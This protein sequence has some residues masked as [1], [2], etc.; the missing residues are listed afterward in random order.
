MGLR[1][2]TRH[3]LIVSA[4]ALF[5]GGVF[6]VAD[7][8][9]YVPQNYRWTAEDFPL[10]FRIAPEGAPGI[11]DGSD[12]EAIRNA[13]QTWET[14]GCSTATF[15]E[16]PWSEPA[17]VNRDT[18]NKV[19]WAKNQAD[20]N[21]VGGQ[22][23]T[24]ALTFV[25]YDTSDGRARDADIISN[26]VDWTWSTGGVGGTGRV[27]DVETVLL[28]E[29]GHFFGLGHTNDPNAVMFPQNNAASRR[30]VTMDDVNGICAL[31][32]GD[33][34]P[35]PVGAP[36]QA[37]TDC[38][39]SVC[40]VDGGNSYC[41]QQCSLEQTNNCPLD[42]PCQATAQG[43]FCLRP[44]QTDELCDQCQ[45]SQQCNTGLCLSVPG[46][47]NFRPFCTRACDPTPG[48]PGQCPQGYRCE[49]IASGNQTGGV[50][51]P[52]T[53]L[54]DPAGKGGHNEFCYADNSCKP[55]HTCV[56]YFAGA[57]PNYCYLTCTTEFAAANGSC[58]DQLPVQCQSIGQENVFGRMNVAVCLNIAKVGEPCVPEVCDQ[59]SVCAVDDSGDPE[60]ATC[61]QTCPTGNCPANSQC[62]SFPSLGP[63]C[64][65]NS[66]FLSLGNS[67]KSNE[68]CKSRKCRSYGD[69]NLCTQDCA[70]TD[71]NG[72]PAGLRCLAANNSTAGLCWPTNSVTP[73]TSLIGNDVANM[74]SDVCYCDITQQCDADCPCDP[75]CSSDSCGC[76]TAFQHDRGDLASVLLILVFVGLMR[77]RRRRVLR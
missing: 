54:C 33:G 21:A 40:V 76:T 63:V 26:G 52:N 38:A 19:F 17:T 11:N 24:L 8:Q 72:C 35:A 43:N 7:A 74:S 56:Q 51:A 48:A 75:E 2:S 41:S 9:A 66:G 4:L 13:F 16:D 20:W 18:R 5:I 60:T 61:Y 15:R 14:V 1:L 50:C 53:G 23:E 42:F 55:N 31:Y 58:S 30:Q 65:P 6:C 69:K 71:P 34:A 62:L 64:V 68:E 47:N 12:I 32:P 29:V 59:F 45:T 39:S 70:T 73:D 67:C 28:H 36:C 10:S 57:G 37:P 44:P 46:Y 25:F 49:A 3:F 77:S 27:A 22:P